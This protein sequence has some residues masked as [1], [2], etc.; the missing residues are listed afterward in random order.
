MKH[1]GTLTFFCGKMG[2]GKSTLSKILATDKNAVLISED[3]LLSSLYPNQ[4]N[5]FEDY[6]R[7]SALLKPFIKLHVQNIL[8]TDTN[9]VMD[10]PANTIN[11]RQW[12]C[13]L[14]Q[15]I[16][17]E[18]QL[19]YLNVT[20]EKCLA[21]ISKRCIEQPERMLFDNETVFNQVTKFFEAPSA[22]ENLNIV[23]IHKL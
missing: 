19:I 21:Q 7:Y 22:L 18:Y 4:I 20:N 8:Q 12:F 15:E 13:T 9:V 16:E 5:S 14:C 10:F 6:L 2:A 23:D 17:A 11:Q 1:I 3:N